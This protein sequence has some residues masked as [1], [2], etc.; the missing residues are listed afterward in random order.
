[1][2]PLIDDFTDLSAARRCRFRSGCMVFMS[3]LNTRLIAAAG[4]KNS[5]S[6]PRSQS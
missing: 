3:D 1:M 2:I 5:A 4:S 6:A